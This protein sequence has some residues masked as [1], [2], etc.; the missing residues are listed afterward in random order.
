ML[1][2]KHL[3]ATSPLNIGS[4]LVGAFVP[5]T[6]EVGMFYSVASPDWKPGQPLT[7]AGALLFR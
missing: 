2:V 6:Q 7:P 5:S 1:S 4:T 3:A